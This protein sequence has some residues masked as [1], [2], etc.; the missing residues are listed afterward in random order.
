MHARTA[1]LSWTAWKQIDYLC[2]VAENDGIGVD[3][4]WWRSPGSRR[5]HFTDDDWSVVSAAWWWQLWCC[6]RWVVAR[7]SLQRADHWLAACQFHDA[8]FVIS[9]AH[10]KCRSILMQVGWE[11]FYVCLSTLQLGTILIHY[12]T[13]V[14]FFEKIWC[15]LWNL[16]D[17]INP[18]ILCEF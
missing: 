16:R 2:I 7:T 11:W 1:S 4:G 3:G 8:L 14:T 13:V 6:W 17:F 5:V 18:V 12:F 9:V 15:F 10:F